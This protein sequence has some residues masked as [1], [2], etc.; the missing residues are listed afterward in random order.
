VRNGEDQDTV[1]NGAGANG[2]VEENP[3]TAAPEAEPAGPEEATELSEAEVLRR[4]LEQA[5]AEAAD[6]KNRFLRARADLENYRR[7]AAQELSRAREAGLDSA[8]LPLLSVYDDLGRAL[9]VSAGADSDPAQL[10]PGIQAVRDGL[11][12]NLGTLGLEEIGDKG[13][14]FNPDLHEA[15]TAV[16]TQD[17]SAANTIA[18]VVQTGFVKD[19][20]LVR[21][22]RVVVFQG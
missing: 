1:V 6:F 3:S 8:V 15:L 21:P 10:I 14:P 2:A 17:E 12:R 22:A 7:R 9:S 5:R 20:R 19:E 4:E 11:K 16:P 13:E 18:E